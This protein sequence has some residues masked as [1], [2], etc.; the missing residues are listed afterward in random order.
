M[1]GPCDFIVCGGRT[2]GCVV[3]SRLSENPNVRVLLLEAGGGDRVPAVI[4]PTGW[5]SNVGSERDW[6]FRARGHKNDFD[7]WAAETGG[8]GWSY[9]SVLKVYKRIE[10]WHGPADDARRGRCGPVHG[11]VPIAPVPLWISFFL[12]C[13]RLYHIAKKKLNG[14]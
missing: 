14:I 12:L 10:N 4:D 8:P 7:M 6:L 3:A 5:M 2:S 1:Q 9:S 11:G 13:N